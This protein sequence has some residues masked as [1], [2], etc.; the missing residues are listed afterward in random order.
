MRRRW[1]LIVG[2][3]IFLAATA[4]AQ[5]V[6]NSHR[7]QTDR[8]LYVYMIDPATGRKILLNP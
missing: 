4:L 1:G 2:L 6:A 3:L 7:P 5:T 8:K